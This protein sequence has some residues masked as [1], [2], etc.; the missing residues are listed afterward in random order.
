M[1]RTLVYGLMLSILIGACGR[2]TSDQNAAATASEAAAWTCVF[3]TEGGFTGGGDGYEINSTGQVLAWS[4]TTS[5]SE[6]QTTP[7]GTATPQQLA[8]LTAA[9]QEPLALHL[10]AETR[11][12]M[13]TFLRWSTQHEARRTLWTWPADRMGGR[14]P[15][16]PQQILLCYEAAQA[17]VRQV[18]AE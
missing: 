18:G 3:G 2:Q 13:T 11:G 12:N 17:I 7:I 1:N 14:E 10:A 8:P 5:T 4:R 15:K 6:R 16:V 9:I